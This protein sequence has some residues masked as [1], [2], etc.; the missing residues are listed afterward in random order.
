MSTVKKLVKEPEFDDNSF[1]V[2]SSF[3]VLVR[4]EVKLITFLI[5]YEQSV[6]FPGLNLV[7][8]TINSSLL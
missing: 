3:N 5:D 8:A 4:I 1:S 2:E 6:I 7:S